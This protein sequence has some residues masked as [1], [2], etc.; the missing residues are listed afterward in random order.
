LFRNKHK[1]SARDAIVSL[2]TTQLRF[3]ANAA[4]SRNPVTLVC[5]FRHSIAECLCRNRR[6]PPRARRYES[7]VYADEVLQNYFPPSRAVITN[8]AAG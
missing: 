5:A 8:I 6:L 7:G 3:V 1:S 4:V 2:S